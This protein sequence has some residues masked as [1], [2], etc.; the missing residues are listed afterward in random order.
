MPELSIESRE[1]QKSGGRS[2]SNLNI[3]SSSAYGPEGLDED[4]E[5]SRRLGYLN[6]AAFYSAIRR[7]IKFITLTTTAVVVTVI[8]TSTYYVTVSTKTFFVQICTPTPFPFS[9]CPRSSG[10]N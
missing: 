4:E 5:L 1:Q 9:V 8:R 10:R 6:L 3:R 2:V 7:R